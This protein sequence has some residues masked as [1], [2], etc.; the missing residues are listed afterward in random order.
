MA[1]ARSSVSA[2]LRRW[3]PLV[4]LI[5]VAFAAWR[6]SIATDTDEASDTP[7]AYDRALGTPLLSARRIPET[8]QAPVADDAIQ[9]A[10]AQFVADLQ[11]AQSDLQS[12]LTVEVEGRELVDVG[13]NLAL[14]PASNQK[15]VTT[16]AALQ[17]FDPGTRF[18]TT[19]AQTGEVVDGVLTGDLYLIG[20]GD[21][22]LVTDS[23]RAQYA[24]V[25]ED[26]NP[27]AP[28][29]PR[30]WSRLEDLADQVAASGI[31]T[32]DGAC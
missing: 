6:T 23:W 16:Y 11:A 21:P 17:Q 2:Q 10:I 22:F 32:V 7:I 3:V 9:P 27:V 14:I 19:V 13:S 5:A 18:T 4:V 1:R 15:L 25:D 12:C 26:G 31:V 24:T 20:G 29:Y 28:Q 8:L 30:P